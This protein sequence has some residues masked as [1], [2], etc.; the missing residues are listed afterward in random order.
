[1]A[2]FLYCE[3]FARAVACLSFGSIL[4]DQ[5][6][7][8]CRMLCESIEGVGC[9]AQ[10]EPC[11]GT[12]RER[13]ADRLQRMTLEAKPGGAVSQVNIGLDAIR[14]TQTAAAGRLISKI[15]R[16]FGGD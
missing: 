15:F 3:I 12:S 5:L 1:M 10:L 16:S 8:K 7:R 13:Q 4:A 9:N 14:L 2:K 6:K 11:M